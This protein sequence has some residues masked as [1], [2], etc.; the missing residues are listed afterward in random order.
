MKKQKRNNSSK[1][2]KG[3]NST[4]EYSNISKNKANHS[5]LCNMFPHALH[6]SQP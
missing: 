4:Y 3:R 6:K 2:E 5:K 1:K